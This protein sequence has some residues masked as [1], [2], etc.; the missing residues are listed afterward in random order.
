MQECDKKSHYN[1]WAVPETQSEDYSQASTR[2]VN[3]GYRKLLLAFLTGDE[4]RL[5]NDIDNQLSR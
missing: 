3:P 5:G 1:E 2:Y 4:D